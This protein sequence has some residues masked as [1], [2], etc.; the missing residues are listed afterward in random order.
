M[1]KQ[2]SESR[3]EFVLGLFETYYKRVFLFARHSLPANQAEDI[4]QEVFIRLLEHKHLEGKVI[5]ASYLITIADNLIKRRYA[6][7]QR[8]NQIIEERFRHW[9]PDHDM[10]ATAASCRPA[11]RRLA[12]FPDLEAELSKLTAEERDAI[13]LIICQGMSYENAANSLNVPVSTVNN[14]KF[15]GLR[16]LRRAYGERLPAGGPTRPGHRTARAG[17]REQDPQPHETAGRDRGARRP[18]D[19]EHPLTGTMSP[20][21]HESPVRA[22]VVA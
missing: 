18:A 21:R 10:N 1:H 12:E 13:H 22:A 6:R 15:R 4:A 3:S 9:D 5:N 2:T 11:D 14:W 8:F 19:R 17:R 16:K 20:L 7:T